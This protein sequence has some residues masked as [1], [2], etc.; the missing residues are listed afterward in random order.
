MAVHQSY[1]GILIHLY[2]GG[3]RIL[4]RRRGSFP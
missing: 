3:D 1:R 4:W 2:Y